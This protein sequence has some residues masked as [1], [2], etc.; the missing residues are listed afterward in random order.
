MYLSEDLE[1]ISI[2]SCRILAPASPPGEIPDT[3][4]IEANYF[5]YLGN[6]RFEV[7]VISNKATGVVY[8]RHNSPVGT[9]FNVVSDARIEDCMR[10][11]E[12]VLATLTT[13][14]AKASPPH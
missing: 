6:Y 2:P 12:T 9:D 10:E 1:S 4:V 8:A 13:V 7:V 11:A 14:Q 3:Q 5:K